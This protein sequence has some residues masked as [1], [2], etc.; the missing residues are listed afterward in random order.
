MAQSSDVLVQ[1]EHWLSIDPDAATRKE[2]ET[3]LSQARD[4]DTQATADLAERF[5][6][7]LQFGTAGLRA[8]L[9]AGP[10]RMNRVVVRRAAAGLA[11]YV[12]RRSAQE[13][14]SGITAVV[15]YDA[16]YNSDIF[17]E[18]TAAIFTAAGIRTLLM[19]SA[20]PT[21]VLAWACR[22]FN[23][24]VGVMVTASHNPPEDNGYKV[25]L[26]GQAVAEHGRG[27]QIVPPYDADI[28]EAIAHIV[29]EEIVLAE[30]GWEVL[31]QNIASEYVETIAGIEPSEPSD[32]RIVY[33]AMH[34][35]GGQTVL[36]VLNDAGFSEVF[37][38]QE[39]FV[40]DPDFPTVS[41]PN[42]EEPGALDLAFAL[43]QQ[44]DAD[45]IIAND[46]DADR[47]SFAVYD[48]HQNAWRQL[49][50]DEVGSLLG[51][52]MVEKLAKTPEGTTN[53]TF[54]NSIVSS[55][56]LSAIAQSYGVRHYQTLTGFKWIAR[57]EGLSYGYEEA[58]GYSVAPELVKDKDGIS[59]ALVVARYAHRLKE[60][61]SSLIEVLDRIAQEHGVYA[62]DQISIRVEDLSRIG[63]MMSALRTTAPS[64]LGDS[65]V[66]AHADLAEGYEGLPPTDG[67]LFLSEDNS[68]VIVR[69]S[70]TEPK[71]KCYVE[72]IVPVSEEDGA[73]V[74]A[75]QQAQERLERIAHTMK[76]A[77]G[78]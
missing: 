52:A 57:I 67:L 72:V 49:R 6:G 41:F 42:P 16:R 2:L 45:L 78:V 27:A 46:P 4:G 71:L 61:G 13:Q 64:A 14:W 20:L 51:V 9:G 35:V 58:I 74:V 25:Y 76:I 24:E 32:L 33:T 29:D 68:R 1:A 65:P 47:A 3:L 36:S 15:G 7:T 39:Q 19:P 17:A 8:A 75:R 26:G 59:A 69:P 73:L 55:R 48:P 12:T 21:P 23:A 62:T 77:L 31:D 53:A 40:P 34:G 5:S 10:M 30:Q 70:G 54:A 18:E 66:N 50:G 11:A 56:Q 37:P 63:Q 43:A 38:V 44:K 22:K 60:Q 28:A